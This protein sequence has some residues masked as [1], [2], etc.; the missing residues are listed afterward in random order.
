MAETEDDNGII[1][2]LDDEVE[3]D[4]QG[5]DEYCFIGLGEPV[6]INPGGGDDSEFDI[7]CPPSQPLAVSQ[8]FAL[9]FVAHSTGFCV[10]RT[11]DIIESAKAIEEKVGGSSVKELSVVDV[12]IGK[13]YILAL[14]ADSSTLAASIDGNIHFFCVTSLLNKEQSPSFSCSLK[15]S[16]CVKEIQWTKK[17]EN[18]YVVLSNHG[19]LYYGARQDPLKHVMDNVDA[20]DWS[21]KGNFVAIA[22]KDVLSIL[23][24][25]F[26]KKFSML[27]SF[28]SWIGDSDLDS[29][30][31]VDSIRW[32]R[33]D[34]IILGCFQLTADGKEESY[35]V[36]VITSKDGK[37][38]DVTAGSKPIV[39]SFS[40]VFEGFI[41]D[42]V[43]F[44]SGPYMSLSYLD[45]CELAITANR[46]NT[47]QHIV[48]FGWSQDDKKEAAVIDILRDTLC[49]KIALQG[50]GDDNMVLGLCLVNISH[51]EKVEV[52]LGA[53]YKE[54]S[55]FCIL[56]C[57]SL[58]GKLFMFQVASVTG[59]SVPSGVVSLLSDEEDDTLTLESSGDGMPKTSSGLAVKSVQEVGRGF[60]FQDVNKNELH[61]KG[62]YGIPVKNVPM[63]PAVKNFPTTVPFA[64]EVSLK[65]TI[66]G[67]GVT[68]VDVEIFKTN[69]QQKFP[70]TKLNQDTD[71]QRSLLS[72]HQGTNVGHS[73]LKTSYL[74]GPAPV[75]SGFTETETQKLHEGGSSPVSSAGKL[76]ADVSS[77]SIPSTPPRAVDLGKEL[78]GKHGSTSSKFALSESSTNAKLN[79]PM[80]S[81]GGS[82]LLP[83]SRIPSN[84]SDKNLNI[85]HLP[86]GSFGNFSYA[87]EG[88]GPSTAIYSSGKTAY[89]GVQN[90][91]TG[92]GIV[93]PLP[94]IHSPQLSSQQNFTFG[95]SSK[96]KFHP[97]KENYT[98]TSP[99]RLL[100]SEP[101]LSK[102][103]GNVEEM[104]K[105]LDTLLECIEEAGGFRDACTVLHRGAVL[106]LEK[107]VEAVFYRCRLSKS[108]M[109]ERR[110][111]IQLILDNTVQVLARK[112]YMEGLVKQAT[113]GKYWDLWN[114]Q[115]L[116]SE[117]E[118]KQQHILKLNQELT[119]Q[120]IELERHLNTLELNKF[121][122]NGVQLSQRAFPGRYGS[123]RHVQSLHSIRNTMS[124]QLAAAEQLSENLSKQM[125][126]LS[127][128]SPSVKK[129]NMRRELFE[130]IGIPYNSA[131]F[132]SPDEKI[133]GDTRYLLTSSRFNAVK[134]ENQSSAVRGYESEISRRR[135][136]SL[137]WSWTSFEPPKT[138]V[139][140]MLL[141]ED[142]PKAST[143]RTTLMDKKSV[144]SKLLEASVVAGPERRTT[145]STLLYPPEEKGT[146]DRP[147]KQASESPST[148]FQW[149]EDSSRSLQSMGLKSSAT[150]VSSVNSFP[151]FSSQS[152]SMSA[153]LSQSN[154]R[155][156]FCPTANQ[157]S[158]GVAVIE[159]SDSLSINESKSIQKSK[160]ELHETPSIS[161][162][163]TGQ[164]L[165]L[166]KASSA[167]SNSNDDQTNLVK[168]TIGNGKHWPSSIER[169]YFES[170]KGHESPFYPASVANPTPNLN[171]EVS[172]PGTAASKSQSGGIASPFTSLLPTSIPSSP[173]L[174]HPSLPLP[175]LSN[176]TAPTT[177]SMGSSSMS[178]RA[179][180]VGSQT[181]LL[182]S[183]S[184]SSSPILSSSSSFQFPEKP[185]PST[186]PIFPMNFKKES[187]KIELQPPILERSSKSD[188][189]STIQSPSPK[190][191][192][193]FTLK[194][195][196]SLQSVPSSE[197]SVIFSGMSTPTTNLALD[198]KQVQPL[199]TD[200]LSAAVLST[201][202][203]AN[204]GK[205]E[206]SDVA[207]SQE[208]EM[209]EE[210][211]ETS[212][213]TELTLGGLGSFGIGSSP[214]PTAAKPNPF[215]ATFSNAAPTPAS[216]PFNMT[217]PTGELFRPASFSFQSPQP[218][219]SSQLTNFGAFSGGFST[220][221]TPQISSGSGFGQPAQIGSG[222]QALGSV[223]GTFGQSR[224]LG[225]VL[226]GTSASSASGFGGGLV[227][228]PST[229]GFASSS[230]G[231]ATLASA[232]G[233]FAGVA[234]AGGGFASASGGF[235]AVASAG[236]GFAAPSAGGGFAGAAAGSGFPSSGGGF[237]AFNSQ[238]GS[239]GF[240]AFG[241]SAGG[242]VRPPSALFTQMRK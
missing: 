66:S 56:L 236:R 90:T 180:T 229:G 186:M 157:S 37:I 97:N 134:G 89:S 48:L 183:L 65:E 44:G 69:G 143:D 206:S 207:V 141:H 216:S 103:F 178:S 81:E 119:N 70:V 137:N 68:P 5:S 55:P 230:G 35:L 51:N 114:R 104:I 53:E 224:Q 64:D 225:G 113:D 75:F 110:G 150:Q 43:P 92:A 175:S 171:A 108:I 106:E 204:S 199:A 217:I 82:S 41:D 147:T 232:G 67:K 77:Q 149:F 156:S 151:V 144:K 154:A 209:E 125:A 102:Q 121:G 219:Q 38:T 218:F 120:L 221:N 27:L 222:Q 231:F 226:P 152:A 42:I 123:S 163:L 140:R 202:G 198:S 162:R 128:E 195:E 242:A 161:K 184:V 107:D 211:S 26:K 3:G 95:K 131:S 18:Y 87:K 99:T 228:S 7:Q 20:V 190:P 19:K 74:E 10:A 165:S 22:R 2:Q 177:I 160:I 138:T 14:S 15:N 241:G 12:P 49:P 205:S 208:D 71:G 203:S 76:L 17:L 166:P 159:M 4:H 182:S 34:C 227:S 130:A 148:S 8:R 238:Q 80:A 62:G 133:T 6:P 1:V 155:G 129:Q 9:I 57:L 11:T 164:T 109:D 84:Q 168:S 16:S 50:N 116:N 112:V 105:E 117:L 193:A 200:V 176:P 146:Q 194:L 127:I 122:E 167:M 188:E 237:G 173:P 21:V 124:S 61:M 235:S 239:G 39:L 60:Q 36:Q 40:D 185:V 215:G 93:N 196:S 197:P 174:I 233:G 191:E 45:R 13:V 136:D 85:A 83:F 132:S 31:K 59:P 118:L 96:D 145:T 78:P 101:H 223:L 142:F 32:V 179:T 187:P 98:A 214:N 100:N 192:S 181:N 210:A 63:L 46:K 33:P 213:T 158:S 212:Q 201:S 115:K 88:S 91:S 72:D 52:K 24:S 58:D 28:K 240:S 79:F 47:D 23:S 25:K 220:G 54:L 86:G 189:S 169:S 170:G 139:K 73:Y 29:T 153:I 126:V 30:V 234:S 172:Q 135:R 111:Q 94:T